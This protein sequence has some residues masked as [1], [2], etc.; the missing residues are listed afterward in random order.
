VFQA[1]PHT[2]VRTHKHAC[3][4]MR[5]W[6]INNINTSTYHVPFG[7]HGQRNLFCFCLD[8]TEQWSTSFQVT[9]VCSLL[10]PKQGVHHLRNPHMLVPS[11][12]NLRKKKKKKLNITMQRCQHE[13]KPKHVKRAPPLERPLP[14]LLIQAY[15]ALI[16]CMVH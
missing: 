14:N 7:Y 11:Q 9:S 12:V 15:S 3:P 6:Q 10:Q 1:L 5:T 2:K 13:S 16:F 8:L 4:D